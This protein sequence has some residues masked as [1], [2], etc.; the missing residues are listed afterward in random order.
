MKRAR[1]R[2]SSIWKRGSTTAASPESSSPIRYEAHPR[3]SGMSCP[4]SIFLGPWRDPS[5]SCAGGV[6]DRPHEL[7]QVTVSLPLGELAVCA[8]AALDHLLYPVELT[9]RAEVLRVRAQ[10]LGQ[11]AGK[12][13]RPDARR[14]RQVDQRAVEPVAGREPLVL[15]Q[16]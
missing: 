14:L 8:G 6:Q 7:L 12:V 13:G 15:L 3:S 4:N 1:S 5:T 9:L 2:Y 11:G 16:H 10:A